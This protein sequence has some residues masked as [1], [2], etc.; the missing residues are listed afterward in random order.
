ME[1]YF[2]YIIKSL[3][4]NGY[5]VGMSS[6]ASKRLIYHNK[7]YVRSTKSRVP[8]RL[9]Y[10]EEY[11]SRI[12]ARNREKYLKSYEGSKEKLGIIDKII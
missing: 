7:G 11:A 3:K 9:I 8:F 2:V 1:K 12:E 6:D 5:Y 10:C 4:D